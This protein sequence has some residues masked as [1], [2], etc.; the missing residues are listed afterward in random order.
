MAENIWWGM[1][2]K[3]RRYANDKNRQI[4]A[5]EA[6]KQTK[7]IEQAEQQRIRAMYDIARKQEIAREQERIEDKKEYTYRRNQQIFDTIGFSYDVVN[8]ITTMIGYIEKKFKILHMFQEEGKDSIDVEIASP[9]NKEFMDVDYSYDKKNNMEYEFEE[10]YK[11]NE[12]VSTYRNL[13]KSVWD[14][15][16][17][18]KSN[19]S[20]IKAVQLL[21]IIAGLILFFSGDGT[22]LS[23]IGKIIAGVYAFLMLILTIN[24]GALSSEYNRKFEK[25]S[26]NRIEYSKLFDQYIKEKTRNLK[27]KYDKLMDEFKEFRRTN[28][29]KEIETALD[30]VGIIDNDLLDESI[31]TKEAY[32]RYFNEFSE[33]LREIEQKVREIPCW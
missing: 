18:K 19:T 12:I 27:S 1:N 15:G 13:E 21:I 10:K 9:D 6:E 24:L 23:N 3:Y 30:L 25:Y 20:K 32:K 7:I 5:D 26:D 29:N 14:L 17:R 22:T 33:K 16:D 2:E 28:Y 11:S 31:G 8:D 4:A